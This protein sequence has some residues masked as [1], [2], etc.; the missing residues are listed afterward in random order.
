MRH[1]HYTCLILVLSFFS[2][3][4]QQSFSYEE[5][6]VLHKP[7]RATINVREAAQ[8]DFAPK[9]M[10][11]EAPVPGN[12]TYRNM[13]DSLKRELYV[14]TNNTETNK[15]QTLSDTAAVVYS[16][17]ATYDLSSAPNDNDIAIS[18]AGKLVSV[19]N[20]NIWI[21][22]IYDEATEPVKI[23][24]DAFAEPLA[25]EQ[26]KYD[27]K[28]AYDPFEDRFILVFLNGTASEN[29][30]IVV[31]FSKTNDP[32]GNWNLFALEGNPRENNTWSDY[33][34]IALSEQ[35]LFISVN[36]LTDGETWQEGFAGSVIWQIYKF[37]GYNATS[38][39]EELI[40]KF[41]D[42]IQYNERNIRNLCP[43][44]GGSTLY[45]PNMYFLSNRNFDVSN[46]SIF[47]LEVTDW[48]L[49]PETHVE[50]Q[51]LQSNVA[52]G[53]PPQA[54]QPNNQTFDTNDGRILGAYLEDNQIHFVSNTMS[55][56]GLSGIYHG[57]INNVL[58][59]NP[60]AEGFILSNDSL[61]L[62]YPNIAYV[63]TFP[64][65]DRCIINVN[66][67]GTNT[68][69]GLSAYYYAY[70]EY[71]DLQILKKGTSYVDA[72]E[73]SYER[74][75]DYSGAQTQYN[76]PGIVW[77]NGS[78]GRNISFGPAFFKGS[79]TW[80]S[81]LQSPESNMAASIENVSSA[82]FLSN[83]SPNP[84]T[85]WVYFDLHFPFKT[86]EKINISLY[87]TQGELVKLL[88]S[89]YAKAGK[90]RFSF[91]TSPLQN[92]MYFLQIND[93]QGKYQLSEKVLVQH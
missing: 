69:D 74:W 20:S 13:L 39:N 29:S 25:L 83:V 16:F 92:G 52:Y 86:K 23:S 82:K 44:K 27:P 84:S 68:Y 85:N 17:E 88:Y 89:D 10:H 58:G 33:P 4:A 19:M 28:I 65:D 62:G 37:S 51:V 34:M 93:T 90:N 32:A 22:D 55:E 75:G 7:L 31:G 78:W 43:V 8:H 72:I 59:E 35:E 76:A 5:S 71:S 36:L 66:H 64:Y 30:T 12:K 70:G 48:F 60:Q 47:L 6:E 63:G 56:N 77:I 18:N 61:D 54:H 11:L 3:H 1:F 80:I 67:S 87:N 40:T 53:V 91:D 2:L 79:S 73:G 14:K 81:A 49:S 41:Y 45:G 50:M 9:M 24:L 26:G 57:K 21:Y 42:N 15:T 38:P 46:D